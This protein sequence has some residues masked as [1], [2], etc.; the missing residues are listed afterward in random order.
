MLLIVSRQITQSS[1]NAFTRKPK[2]ITARDIYRPEFFGSGKPRVYTQP[3][4]AILATSLQHQFP[5]LS[6]SI[7]VDAMEQAENRKPIT[8]AAGSWFKA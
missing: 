8:L 4:R 5:S 1:G 7:V 6:R 3:I 2:R